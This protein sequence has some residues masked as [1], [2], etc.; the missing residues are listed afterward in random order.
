MDDQLNPSDFCLSGW[1]SLTLDDDS[2]PWILNHIDCFD[3]QARL[4][5][6]IKAVHFRWCVGDDRD[7]E[8]WDKVGKAIG[9][10]QALES[11]SFQ[12]SGQGNDDL[13]TITW[14][15]WFS[16]LNVSYIPTILPRI[17]RHVR[18]K[19]TLSILGVRR[20]NVEE[21]RLLAQAIYGHPTITRFEHNQ[22]FPYKSLDS[23]YSALATLPALESIRLHGC[24]QVTTPEDEYALAHPESLTELLQVTSLRSVCFCGFN[25]T[26]AIC[27]ATTNA[28]MEGAAIT[29]LEYEF[30]SISAGECAAM[31]ASG[32][33][34]NTSLRY[35]KVVSSRDQAL[36]DVLA[37]ALPSNSTLRRLDLNCQH[38]YDDDDIDLSTVL[39]ALGENTGVKEVSFN[40]FGSMD[41]SLCTAMKDGLGMN[42]TL[43]SLKL[44]EVHPTDENFDLWCRAFSFLYTNKTLKS[45][46]INL[47]MAVSESRVAAFRS[48]VVAMLQENTSLG[49]LSIPSLYAL[50]AE[51]Y[52]E[53]ITVLQHNMTLKSLMLQH[54]ILETCHLT[55]DEDKQIAVILQKNYALEILPDI[56]LKNETT[57]VGAILRLNGAGRRYLI[58]DGSSIS[59]GVVVLS[60]VNHDINCVFL[61]L[62]ENPRLCDRSAV[63]MGSADGQNSCTSRNPTSND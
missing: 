36:F 7:G 50:K 4:N 37:T 21:S 48:D 57:D 61:H 16:R 44:N 2:I 33:S 40:G 23:L 11:L 60:R 8:I 26:P 25:F 10:L 51:E 55:D 29:S 53:H 22:D 1:H 27:Q 17:L 24:N 62:S 56:N 42:T 59:K 38:F 54:A 13:S 5:E 34:R 45:L 30:C 46:F 43:E 31:M 52:V 32:L 18:Q 49:H 14:E 19:I 41:E 39:L 58:E 35:I 63:E 12:C 20:W 15:I 28:L 47:S 3:T 9:N 6:S